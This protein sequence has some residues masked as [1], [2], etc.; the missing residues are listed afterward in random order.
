[1]AAAS[2]QATVSLSVRFTLHGIA[3]RRVIRF[4]GETQIMIPHRHLT[5]AVGCQARPRQ[6]GTGCVRWAIWKPV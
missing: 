2:Q 6:R 4:A 3:L 1:M 5:Q